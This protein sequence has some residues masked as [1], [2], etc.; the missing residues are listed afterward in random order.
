MLFVVAHSGHAGA[1]GDGEG[2]ARVRGASKQMGDADAFW[3]Y[4]HDGE[5]GQPPPPGGKR[6]LSAFGRDV[7]AAEVPVEYDPVSRRLAVAG[8]AGGRKADQERSLAVRV[9]DAIREASDRNQD[10]MSATELFGELGAAMTGPKS[11]KVRQ[12]IRFAERE[13]WITVTKGGGNRKLHTLGEKSPHV[14]RVARSSGRTLVGSGDPWRP[15][16]A[17]AGDCSDR[18]LDED[19]AEGR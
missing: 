11:T 7:A 1:G 18:S 12:A 3:S 5:N 17:S 16:G 13:Q 2:F 8:G 10:S 15:W 19:L 14:R 9:H 4:K 6:Y